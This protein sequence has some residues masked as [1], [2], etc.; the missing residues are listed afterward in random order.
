[1]A[2]FKL[3]TI[4]RT[5]LAD[6][7]LGNE[8]ELKRVIITDGYNS[9]LSMETPSQLNGNVLYS[10]ETLGKL[11]ETKAHIEIKDTRSS[12]TYTAKTIALTFEKNNSE[13][14]FSFASDSSMLFQKGTGAFIAL[15]DVSFDT[16]PTITFGNTSVEFPPATDSTK[17]IVRFA[18]QTE[19]Q[20]GTGDGV[21]QANKLDSIIP[22]DYVDLSTVQTITGA[23]TFSQTINATAL[24]AISD[25]NGNEIKS[26]SN[27]DY[28]GTIDEESNYDTLTSTLP[29]TKAVVD[30]V[31]DKI[32]NIDFEE[33]LTTDDLTSE[34]SVGAIG[35]YAY[36]EAGSAKS[37]G[38]VINGQYLK[39]ISIHGNSSGELSFS[40]S[41]SILTG[42]WKLLSNAAVRKVNEFCIVFAIKI[43]NSSVNAQRII[44]KIS[45][46]V[47]L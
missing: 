2:D 11:F 23:K 34:N 4:G 26:A 12:E 33:A 10:E 15:I 27:L 7:S 42:E 21:V 19:I 47:Y 31:C 45:E 32:E 16:A 28:T 20:N 41:E 17:G 3:T 24:K 1:M 5:S 43:S 25:Q 46:T 40:R 18:T 44:P 13:Y 6:A 37:Q 22:D 35:M 36:I 9:N 29:T 39:P 8:I 30:Y 38:S 14:V